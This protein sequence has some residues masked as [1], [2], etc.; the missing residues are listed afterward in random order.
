MKARS[1]FLLLLLL[2]IVYLEL[3]SP[4]YLTSVQHS[5]IRSSRYDTTQQTLSSL[6]LSSTSSSSSS[7]SST[8]SSS[9]STS[10]QSSSI[11]EW[12]RLVYDLDRLK[13]SSTDP[14]LCKNAQFHLLP[15]PAINDPLGPCVEPS[16]Y[17]IGPNPNWRKLGG[18]LM[19]IDCLFEK[20]IF[21]SRH[22]LTLPSSN[23]SVYL[24]YAQFTP[25]V[26]TIEAKRVRLA[27]TVYTLQTLR[28]QFGLDIEIILVEMNS[29]INVEEIDTLFG[30]G[31]INTALL[32][33]NAQG[34]DWRLYQEGLHFAWHRL[35]RFEW[36]IVM[37][38][39]MIGPISNFPKVLKKATASGSRLYLT[40][41]WG[42]CCMRGFLLGFH[43]TAI[44]SSQW[45]AF[46]ER[47]SFPCG[48]LGPMFLGEAQLSLP[49]LSWG[50]SCVTSTQYP[51]SKTDDLGTMLLTK[52]PFLYR[53]G[54]VHAFTNNEDNNTDVDTMLAF[55]SELEIEPHVEV[56]GG[57]TV[58][59]K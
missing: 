36:V 53:T 17:E 58:F 50:S 54:V 42:G 52:S 19:Q 2:P 10:I 55:I 41:N 38:D 57:Y 44:L 48:K 51:L 3:S 40:S 13:L 33:V 27:L 5:T 56:C 20:S 37:N 39:R 26:E 1:R 32:N 6:S 7:S 14:R 25:L 34:Q 22:I 29:G 30:I 59:V 8:S 15:R 28:N 45:K 11:S 31:V 12:S 43:K 35:D 47:I 24:V 46:W 16:G 21:T 9:S 18:K 23:A 4:F 49:P